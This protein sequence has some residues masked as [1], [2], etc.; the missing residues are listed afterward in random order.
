MIAAVLLALAQAPPPE[1]VEAEKA[2]LRGRPPLEKPLHSTPGG[3]PGEPRAS[4]TLG[5]VPLEFADR[6]RGESDPGKLLFGRVAEYYAKASAGKFEL[7][8]RVHAPV[9]MDVA[10]EKFS[11]KDLGRALEAFLAREG[12]GLLAAYDG[13]AF[14][15]SGPLAKRG[16]ALWPRKTALRAAGRDVDVVLLPEEAG[17]LEL[18]IAAH[19]FMHLLGFLDKYDDEKAAVG[20]WCI[21]GTGYAAK[22]PP[23]PCADCREKLGW[24]APA[25]VDPRAESRLV[26][27]PEPARTLKVPLNADGSEALV[28]EQRERLFVWHTGGGKRIELVGRY[29]TDTNDRLTPLS[30]PAFQ[31]RT[32]GARPVWITDIRLEDGKAWFRIGPEAPLTPLEEWRRARIGK[33]LGD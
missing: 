28:L 24:T 23:P 20:A 9:A 11:D 5:V 12:E 19:E 31:G 18:S 2:R 8:G 17:G 3:V 22:E 14:V 27:P 15:A 7:R 6:R 21:L 10:R 1:L 13:L 26:L 32:V 16:T 4:Y 33:R 29:P 25:T 30:E